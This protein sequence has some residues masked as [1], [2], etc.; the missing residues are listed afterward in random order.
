MDLE[1]VSHRIAALVHV[2][3]VCGESDHASLSG[4]ECIDGGALAR[5]D[6]ELE[7]IKS[8]LQKLSADG[9]ENVSMQDMRVNGRSSGAS[10]STG[11]AS[12][13][14]TGLK[15]QKREACGSTGAAYADARG[16]KRPAR[17]AHDISPLAYLHDEE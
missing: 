9:D 3:L 1:E 13:G 11:G 8:K 12:T 16:S 6:A 14:A 5:N 10:S 4:N 15:Q 2:E 7:S 17:A